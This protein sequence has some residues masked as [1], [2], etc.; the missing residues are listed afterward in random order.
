M[1]NSFIAKVELY[2]GAIQSCPVCQA[3]GKIGDP[4]YVQNIGDETNKNWVRCIDKDCFVKQGGTLPDGKKQFYGK[5]SRTAEE[6]LAEALQYVPI[7]L[8]ESDAIANQT[9]GLTPTEKRIQSSVIFKG[10]VEI[11]CRD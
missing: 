1:G 9:E 4:I 10:Y 7:F 8:R 3:T 6:R 11:F 5:K 2:N